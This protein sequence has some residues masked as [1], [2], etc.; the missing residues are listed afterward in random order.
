MR[1]TELALAAFFMAST[2]SAATI[3]VTTT[4]DVV[5]NDADCSLRE[6]VKVANADSNAIEDACTAGSGDD[7]INVPAGTYTLSLGPNGASDED[8]NANGDLDITSNMTISGADRDTTILRGSRFIDANPE[9]IFDIVAAGNPVFTISNLTLTRGGNISYPGGAILN[10]GTGKLTV[11]NCLFEDNVASDGGAIDASTAVSNLEITGSL[12]RNNTAQ[13]QAGGVN[14][15]GD[16]TITDTSI[17]NNFAGSGGA[18]R[19]HLGG[20]VTLTNSHL[21]G[22]TASGQGGAMIMN[23]LTGDITITDSSLDGNTAQSNAGGA[24]IKGNSGSVT[25]QNSSLSGN[26]GHSGGAIEFGGTNLT[27][28]DESR[29]DNNK[30]IGSQGGAISFTSGAGALALTDTSVSG[31]SSQF[32][33]GGIY[34]TATGGVAILRSQIDGNTVNN[35]ANSGGGVYYSGNATLSI[36]D[37]SVSENQTGGQGGGVYFSSGAA[38]FTV[39]NSTLSLNAASQ[40]AAIY[41]QGNAAPGTTITN[42]TFD[43]NS[44][45]AAG[46]ADLQNAAG[47]VKV[48]NSI[49]G[50][51]VTGL[52]CVNAATITSLGH[53]IDSGNSCPFAASGD[54]LNTDAKLGPLVLNGGT[55]RTQNLASDSPAIDTGDNAGCPAAD[56][57]GVTRPLDGDSNGTATC[58]IG[59]LEFNH[60]GDGAISSGEACDDGN[61][62]NTDACL[63]TCVAAS[64]GDGFLQNGVE[65]CDDGNTVDGDD[66]NADCTIP[67]PGGTT[68]GDT[69]GGD[70][71]GGT[72]GDTGGTGGDTAG[73]TSGGSSGSGGCSLVR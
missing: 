55:T 21:D 3:N 72:A 66:C 9:R 30:S 38:G 47:T 63:N 1:F 19:Q 35:P 40:G 39:T 23:G 37:S 6:A 24:I 43:G 14:H 15:Q 27:I 64:C 22:N 48:Q 18:Y 36:T 29:L 11:Q 50:A 58:D 44:S 34:Y 59:A 69:T 49:L 73:E 26:S 10:D 65:Q 17:I 5:A 4:A 67:I 32:S 13:N 57:R 61:S 70:T 16:A 56:Q 46:G 8:A 60:C 2:A 7:V 28:S 20:N 52:N 62:E 25:I 33:G 68:G 12:L 54:Q 42:A 71:T 45:G 31:N 51:A 53:N 41:N